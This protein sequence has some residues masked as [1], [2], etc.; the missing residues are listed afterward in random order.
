[1]GCALA[2][3]CS[4]PQQARAAFSACELFPHDLL[5]AHVP[6]SIEN[7]WLSFLTSA[8]PENDIERTCHVDIARKRNI[9]L[10]LARLCGWQTVLFLD[11]D[12]RSAD[13]NTI[14]RAVHLIG[15][16]AAV[17][18][19][20]NDY[21]DNSVVCHAH[22]LAG[23]KQDT[24]PGGSALI[25]DTTR[26]DSFFPPIYNEDWLFLFDAVQRRCVTVA[27]EL[28]QLAYDPF[29][30]SRRA[31]AEEFGDVIA[32]GLYRLVH[33]SVDVADAKQAYWEDMLERRRQFIDGTAARLLQQGG[34]APALMSL[35][36]ARKR[37][38]FISSLACVSFTH[39]WLAD[40]DLWRER[41]RDLPEVGDLTGAA[42][43]LE[44]QA[45][46]KSVHS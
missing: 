31:A 46:E 5:V 8:H 25:I 17:G 24:F 22:R 20:I 15:R 38:T 28:Q 3:L 42:K 18:F 6:R 19:A 39:A 7:T 27:G 36:A 10:L 1:M 14:S 44:L 43:F 32:E 4:T 29:A 26:S 13:R 33:E 30:Q 34:S 37:L 21:P 45:L 23:G 2:V 40:L 11:D 9:G 16:Y 41:L 35:A 12:I